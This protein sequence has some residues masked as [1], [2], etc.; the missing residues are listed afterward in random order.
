LEAQELVAGRDLVGVF[1]IAQA[2]VVAVPLAAVFSFT[3]A[4]LVAFAVIAGLVA[5]IFFGRRL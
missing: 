5:M 3:L 2:F 1:A 4:F